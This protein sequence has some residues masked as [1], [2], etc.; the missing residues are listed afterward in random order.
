MSEENKQGQGEP[1]A[2]TTQR[3]LEILKSGNVATVYP[4]N[5]LTKIPVFLH[6]D[7]GEVEQLIAE[8]W[9]ACGGKGSATREELLSA[10]KLMDEADDE[11]VA[12]VERLRGAVNEWETKWQREAA[13]AGLLR[14]QLAERDALLRHLYDHNELSLGDDQLILA[15][16]SAS[17]EP[18]APEASR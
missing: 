13:Q 7:P 16:L 9:A 12:E 1:V 6:A 2:W 14:A 5:V 11:Q 17:A 10:L 3:E 8:C 18:S 15:A 4:N